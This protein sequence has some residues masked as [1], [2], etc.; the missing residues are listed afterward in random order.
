M[1]LAAREAGKRSHQRRGP[2]EH[3]AANCAPLHTRHASIVVRMECPSIR[4]PA[5]C[6][7]SSKMISAWKLVFVIVFDVAPIR[8]AMDA[9]A[10]AAARTRTSGTAASSRHPC[11]GPAAVT[12]L[13]RAISSCHGALS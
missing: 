4:T 6:I 2:A 8:A 7:I 3:A 13:L 1:R 11:Y 12:G 10:W 9:S 5:K